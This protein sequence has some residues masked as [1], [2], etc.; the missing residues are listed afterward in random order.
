MHI[1]I[2]VNSAWYIANF[3]MSLIRVLQDDCHRITA[4]VPKDEPVPALRATGCAVEFL[5]MDKKSISP[6][7][8]LRLVLNMRGTFARLHPDIVF[9]YTIKNNI[10]GALAA[11]SLGIPFVPNITGLGT[12]FLGS[13]QSDTRTHHRTAGFIGFHRAQRC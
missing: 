10:Y 13:L 1:V 7:N 8:D 5:Q 6:K 2:T 12:A 9:S 4:L 11:R 3:C